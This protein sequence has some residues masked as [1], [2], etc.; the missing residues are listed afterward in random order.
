MYV[1]TYHFQLELMLQLEESI[2]SVL[3]SIRFYCSQPEIDSETQTAIGCR[4]NRTVLV[5]CYAAPNVTCGGATYNESQCVFQK[6]VPCRY[7]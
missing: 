6:E 7:V 4:E 2:I 1:S 3:T 5:P